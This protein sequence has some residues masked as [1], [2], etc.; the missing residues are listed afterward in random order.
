MYTNSGVAISGCFLLGGM[1]PC[2]G[3]N[4]GLDGWINPTT[5]VNVWTDKG[6]ASIAYRS[7]E[8]TQQWVVSASGNVELWRGP[9]VATNL[10]LN[11]AIDGSLSIT[12]AA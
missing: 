5:I 7:D 1:R 3:L 12:T 9:I 2:S 8:Q 6:A 10:A 4:M 11:V